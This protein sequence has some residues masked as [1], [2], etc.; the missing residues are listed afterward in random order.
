MRILDRYLTREF[1]KFYFLFALFLVAIFVLTEFFTSMGHLKKEA[2][3]FQVTLYYILQIP[4]LFVLLSPLSV[5]IST[6]F[7]TSYFGSTNQLQAMQISGISM[8]RAALPLFATALIIGF[9]LL[10]IDNTVVYEVNKISHTI[11]EKNF[12]TVPQTKIHKNIFM[13]VP[14]DHMFYI[15]SLNI[16]E[17][18][19]QGVLIYTNTPPTLTSA[20]EAVWEDNVWVLHRGR[21]YIL[22]QEPEEKPFLQKTFP[23]SKEPRYFIRTYFPPERMSISELTQYI[24]EYDQSGFDTQD[25]ETELHFKI[26]SPFANFI[27][28]L[29]ALSL[30]VMLRRGRGASLAIGLLMSFGYYELMALFKALG[31]ADVIGPFSSAWIPNTLF[32]IAGIYLV[33]KM[34]Q[35]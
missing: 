25:L 35:A 11:K 33:Y 7:A 31:K 23:V 14:P 18:L 20:E 2:S 28:I 4:H 29:V 34:E 17:G 12:V 21:D 32:L 19:M 5:I 10:F 13:T 8:K 22:N 30:G 9:S 6:L 26:S 24:E 15:R 1:L 27:L 16:E 3:I